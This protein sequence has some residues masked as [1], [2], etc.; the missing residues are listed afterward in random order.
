MSV[1][2]EV[3]DAL[4]NQTSLR[5]LRSWWKNFG[6]DGVVVQVWRRPSGSEGKVLWEGLSPSKRAEELMSLWQGPEEVSVPR[7]IRDQALRVL[8][9]DGA[10]L[11][12]ARKRF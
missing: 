5:S 4:W 2:E 12:R 11:R 1:G 7:K 6:N 9:R 3:F 8:G 10:S